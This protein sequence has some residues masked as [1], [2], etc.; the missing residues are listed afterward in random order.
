MQMRH[1]FE[2]GSFYR[3]VAT[4]PANNPHER[5]SRAIQARL[6]AIGELCAGIDPRHIVAL[7]ARWNEVAAEDLDGAAGSLD[8]R[9]ITDARLTETQFWRVSQLLLASIDP[10]GTRPEHVPSSVEPR[11]RPRDRQAAVLL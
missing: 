3:E 8:V 10:E 11:W 2:L 6:T 9:A 4:V 1:E 5:I 7:A